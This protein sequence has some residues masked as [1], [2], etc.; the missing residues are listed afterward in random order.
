[1]SAEQILWQ[2]VVLKALEDAL[3]DGLASSP[4]DRRARDD[5]QRWLE[6]GGRDF[7]RV[8]ALAGWD[9]DFIRDAYRGGRIDRAR[10]RAADNSQRLGRPRGVRA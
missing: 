10:L 7:H 6:G 8:C 2:A 4:D 1:M 9:S 3:N 5:A